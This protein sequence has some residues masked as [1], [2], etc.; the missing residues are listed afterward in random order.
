MTFEAALERAGAIIRGRRADCPVCG[1]KQTVA[2]DPDKGLYYCHKFG[3][4]FSG[5]ARRLAGAE[6]QF[7]PH[8]TAGERTAEQAAALAVRIWESA[9]PAPAGHPYLQR[10]GVQ[11][12]GARA[13]NI[14]VLPGT[15]PSK[16]TKPPGPCYAINAENAKRVTPPLVLAGCDAHGAI[17]TVQFIWSDG[18]KRFLR[19]SSPRGCMFP[20][21]GPE[22]GARLWVC[23]GFATAATVHEATGDAAVAAFSAGNLL[24]AARA[25]RERFPGVTLVIASDNDRATQGNPG[26][27]AA[28]Q[29]ADAVGCRALWPQFGDGIAGTDWNDYA[30]AY[31]IEAARWALLG[32]LQ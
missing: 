3:C 21:G 29:A 25:L 7:I 32:G 24:A 27:A 10:K 23:E 31:G 19:G 26:I 2:L 1:G 13:Q 11:P 22:P 17:R 6:V 16:P 8:P 30:A 14:S 12:H 20:I 15:E 28:K 5:S 4:T 18:R 9:T